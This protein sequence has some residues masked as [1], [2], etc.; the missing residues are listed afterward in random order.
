MSS[1]LK[2]SLVHFED[3]SDD[4]IKLNFLK[5]KLRTI[6]VKSKNIQNPKNKH[7]KTLIELQN[8]YI[9]KSPIWVIKFST[10]DI[11]SE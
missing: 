11:A 3:I 9:E 8:F 5:S 6:N 4:D 10:D 2:I 1:S 7:F